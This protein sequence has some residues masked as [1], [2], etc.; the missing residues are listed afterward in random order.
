MALNL[1]II[2]RVMVVVNIAL[3]PFKFHANSVEDLEK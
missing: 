3:Y 2:Q 1:I